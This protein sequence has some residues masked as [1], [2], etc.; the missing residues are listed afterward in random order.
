MTGESN[1]RFY[2]DYEELRQVSERHVMKSMGDEPIGIAKAE[3]VRV[4]AADG[5]EYL[6]AISGEWVVNLGYNHP[7]IREAVLDQLGYAE[8]TTPVWE[9]QPNNSTRSS[10]PFIRPTTACRGP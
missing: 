6:D 4:T 9:S 10:S 8:Y 3:G 2:S 1:L 5:T 7:K